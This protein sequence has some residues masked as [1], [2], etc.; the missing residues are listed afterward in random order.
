[1][2]NLI[3][4]SGV[5]VCAGGAALAGI[6][7]TGAG[8][9]AAGDAGV[10]TAGAGAGEAAR[11][12]AARAGAVLAGARVA[13]LVEARFV[14]ALVPVSVVAAGALST[15][16]VVVSLL[17]AGA[18]SVGVGWASCAKAAVAES[19]RV[20]AIAIVALE[21]ARRWIIMGNNRWGEP[22]LR[23]YRPFARH[24]GRAGRHFLLP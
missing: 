17:T 21:R 8:F 2:V 15:L 18:G 16:G 22:P 3:D 5:A 23:Y 11:G 9:C 24:P 19:A 14:V 20:A 10:A 7:R 1:L 6:W 12:A 4:E 13:G